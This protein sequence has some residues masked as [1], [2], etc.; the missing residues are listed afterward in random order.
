M[1][2]KLILFAVFICAVLLTAL[3]AFAVHKGAG[4][5]DC[6]GCHTMHGSEGGVDIGTANYLLRATSVED[7]C[8]SCHDSTGGRYSTYSSSV[9]VIMNATGDPAAGDFAYLDATNDAPGSANSGKGHNLGEGASAIT[10]AGGTQISATT[11]F[12]CTN[13]HDSHGVASDSA[14]VSAYRNLRFVPKGAGSVPETVSIIRAAP[15]EGSLSGDVY[16]ITANSYGSAGVGISN[17]S[18]WCGSCHDGFFGD[19]NT[20]TASPYKRHPTSNSSSVYTLADVD[21]ANYL[22]VAE[23]SRFPVEDT[24]GSATANSTNSTNKSAGNEAADSVFC[25]SCHKPHASQNNDALRW[26][27]V[28]TA[29][30]SPGSGCQQCHNK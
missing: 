15:A 20:N 25:L 18:A 3:P 7:L 28:E 22:A 9:P 19:G 4:G 6:S 29:Q 11:G 12:S 23:G 8:L 21:S 14:D 2:K 24:A 1:S 27:Y 10:P 30:S 5:L 16:P 13:C 26:A 17:I